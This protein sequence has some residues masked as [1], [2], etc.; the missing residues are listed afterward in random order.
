LTRQSSEPSIQSIADLP[1]TG[2][3]L[4]LRRASQADACYLAKCYNQIEFRRLYRLSFTQ[5][6]TLE[7]FERSLANQKPTLLNTIKKID[8]IICRKQNKPAKLLPIGLASLIDINLIHKTA[9]FQIGIV[10]IEN[11]SAG[12]AAEASF[13]VMEFAFK[14]LSL[15]KLYS[16][17]YGF[18]LHSQK[19]TLSL[20]FT[21][22]GLLRKQ[23]WDP[24]EQKHI[25]L[26]FNGFLALEF[27]DNKRIA[28]LSSRLVGRDVTSRACAPQSLHAQ[29]KIYSRKELSA[30]TV[31]FKQSISRSLQ[32]NANDKSAQ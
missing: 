4:V 13:L 11:R 32:S 2:R 7:D 1:F 10:Q 18:N 8:W 23:Y 3:R 22:E 30:M 9:E 14:V 16:Y 5:P 15:H 25:D 29:V 6:F 17:V 24:I 26:F 21:Q 27:W 31:L 28:K 20:G 19:G 12:V